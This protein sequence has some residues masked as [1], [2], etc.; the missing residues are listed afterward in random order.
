ME[1]MSDIRPNAPMRSNAYKSA[2]QVKDATPAL[3]PGGVWFYRALDSLPAP[4][5]GGSR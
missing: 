1:K 3:V 5:P 2:T 4:V